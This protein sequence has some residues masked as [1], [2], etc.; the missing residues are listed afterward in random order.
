MDWSQNRP[1]N[2]L[3]QYRSVVKEAERAEDQDNIWAA[4]E[5]WRTAD[6]LW[7]GLSPEERDQSQRF[8]A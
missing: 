8:V 6:R 5:L 4:E 3:A 1:Y 7:L 2:R